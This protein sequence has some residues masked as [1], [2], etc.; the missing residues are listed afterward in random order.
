MV[1]MSTRKR[2]K[3]TEHRRALLMGEI[4]ETKFMVRGTF[5]QVY[6]R[7]G[8]PTCWC[9]EGE[10]HLSNRITWTEGG[11]SRTK[12]IPEEDI[13]WIKSMT[14]NYKAFRKARQNIRELAARLSNLLDELEREIVERTNQ[15][16]TYL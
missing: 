2:I 9:A 14:Q 4:L 15:K 7:C 5:G 6:R 1:Q 10:G 16:R 8:K 13:A 3:S 12:A 11:K